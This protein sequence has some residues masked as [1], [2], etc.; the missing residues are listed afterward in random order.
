MSTF[1]RLRN[2]FAYRKT[3]FSTNWLISVQKRYSPRGLPRI[4]S[5]NF[6]NNL[7]VRI[8]ENADIIPKK[9]YEIDNVIH[10][11]SKAGEPV[12][13]ADEK[14]M[15]DA[16]TMLPHQVYFSSVMLSVGYIC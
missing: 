3:V 2:C 4:A 11:D 1:T 7:S 15:V 16:K 10:V 9:E 5:E 14:L 12:Y 8:S 6:R 13:S